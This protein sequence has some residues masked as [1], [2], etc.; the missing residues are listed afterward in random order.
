MFDWIRSFQPGCAYAVRLASEHESQHWRTWAEEVPRSD[1][2]RDRLQSFLEA[3]VK[4]ESAQAAMVMFKDVE[5]PEDLARL[6]NSLCAH[7]S[8]WCCEPE[9]IQPTPSGMSRFSVGLR[10]NLPKGHVAHALGF[11]PFPFFPPTRRAPY[12]A[13]TVPTCAASGVQRDPERTATDRHLCDMRNDIF[14]ET[15]ADHGHTTKE[16]RGQLT[17][18]Y[19]DRAAK[20]KVTFVL[21]EELRALIPD[22]GS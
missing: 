19:N 12:C 7:E 4:H 11:G 17:E 22:L 15:W 6:V 14:E 18:D 1:E 9:K 8:W 5:E 2:S 21:P 20:A 3:A 16:W 10:W 13:L